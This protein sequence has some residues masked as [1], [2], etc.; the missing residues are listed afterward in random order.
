[1]Y[2]VDGKEYPN[3]TLINWVLNRFGPMRERTLTLVLL[4]F[5]LVCCGLA[6]YFR[7]VLGSQLYSL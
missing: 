6:L 3:M 1:M 7:L 5:Q 2:S 4:A